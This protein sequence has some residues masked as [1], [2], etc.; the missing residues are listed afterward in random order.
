[1]V[2]HVLLHSSQPSSPSATKP[3]VDPVMKSE[4]EENWD[5]S[6]NKIVGVKDPGEGQVQY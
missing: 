5:F 1:M 6:I 4:A 3:G 2:Q